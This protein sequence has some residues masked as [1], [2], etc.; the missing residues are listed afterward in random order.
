MIQRSG[1]L[2]VIAFEV[3]LEIQAEAARIPIRTADQAPFSIHR[4]Q[5][6]VIEGPRREIDVGR[7]VPE[8]AKVRSHRPVQKPVVTMFGDQDVDLHAPQHR[9][10]NG[11]LEALIGQEIGRDD[12]D[13]MLGLAQRR[14]QNGFQLVEIRIW[15]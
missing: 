12:A 6:G 10:G 9:L 2:A 15:S 4:D 11:E 7:N 8:K 1:Q 5:L 3:E 14:T 13:A